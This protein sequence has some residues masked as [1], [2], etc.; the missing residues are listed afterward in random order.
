MFQDLSGV[1]F[2]VRRRVIRKGRT[3][4]MVAC[5]GQPAAPLMVAV[6]EV[7]GAPVFQPVRVGTFLSHGRWFDNSTVPPGLKFNN[8]ALR[9]YG[10]RTDGRLDESNQM[11]IYFR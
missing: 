4:H 6:V 7:N 10:I 3:L 1:G 11:D 2:G 8:I 5:G 9:A